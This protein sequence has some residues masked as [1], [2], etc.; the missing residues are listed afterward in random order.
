MIR[1]MAE[2]YEFE[3]IFFTVRESLGA[4]VDRVGSGRVQR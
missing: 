1:K 3:G 2:E 4:V